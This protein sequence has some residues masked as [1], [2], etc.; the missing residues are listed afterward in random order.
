MLK[1]LLI[2]GIFFV[3]Y[4]FVKNLLRKGAL[5][6]SRRSQQSGDGAEDMVGCAQ[7]GVHLPRSEAQMG[8]GK[9]YCCDAHARLGPI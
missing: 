2:A 7:C 3:A 1:F 9:F 8:A 6:E 5:R 4:L